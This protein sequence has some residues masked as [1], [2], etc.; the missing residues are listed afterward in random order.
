M[1]IKE[2]PLSARHI[3]P[4]E[5]EKRANVESLDFQKLLF[6][7]SQRVKGPKPIDH[8]DSFQIRSQCLKAVEE[9]LNTLEAYQENLSLLEI[10]LKK[11]DPIIQT[12]KE[13]VETLQ[14]LSEKLPT[15]DPLRNIMAE[16]GILSTVEIE[17][18]RRGDYL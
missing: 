7:A 1:K 17:K 16:T 12:L 10:S 13:E 3:I 15:R 8:T 4:S 18:F 9:T 5:T 2:C 11:V 6:E 14:R